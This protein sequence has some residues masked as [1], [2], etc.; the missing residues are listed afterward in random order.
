MP[1]SS[2]EKP[3][4]DQIVQ[5]LLKFRY[6][7]LFADLVILEKP[8]FQLVKRPGFIEPPPDGRRDAVEAVA[9]ARVGIERDQLVTDISGKEVGG[10]FIKWLTHE[11][12]LRGTG[13][14][15]DNFLAIIR[16]PP[17]FDALMVELI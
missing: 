13:R 12:G 7:L 1:G 5:Q 9:M 16:A 6:A 15:V 11:I 14:D 17:L 4:A 3:L 2:T 8:L 10:T